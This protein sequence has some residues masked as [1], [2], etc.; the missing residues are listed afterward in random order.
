MPPQS[1]V[2]G[3]A[4]RSP[5]PVF[6]YIAR[7]TG[8]LVAVT[9]LGRMWRPAQPGR[10]HHGCYQDTGTAE[11]VTPGGSRYQAMGWLACSGYSEGAATCPRTGLCVAGRTLDDLLE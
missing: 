1:T 7:H 3:S 11:H 5:Q 2:S 9:R 6:V 8:D 4:A 10:W